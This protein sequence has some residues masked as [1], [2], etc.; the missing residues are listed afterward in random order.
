MFARFTQLMMRYN[1]MAYVDEAVQEVK[2]CIPPITHRNDDNRLVE[3]SIH[4]D[5]DC[6]SFRKFPT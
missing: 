3:T 4:Q 2:E 6:I 5:L 1:E